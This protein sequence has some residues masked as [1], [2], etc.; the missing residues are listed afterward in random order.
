MK[1]GILS[2]QKI[3]NYGSFLQA[4]SLKKQLEDRGHD[5]Y[6]VD[7]VPG[8][9]VVAA[10]PGLTKRDIL[11]RIDRHIFSRIEHYFFMKKMFANH[12][13]DYTKWLQTD[14]KLP[15]G[16]KYDL[17]IIGSDEVFNATAPSPWG[18]STQLFGNVENAKRVVTYAASCGQTD[19]ES[20]RACGIDQQIGDCLRRLEA[21]SVRDQN[22]YNF[23]E[24]IAGKQA[25]LH[26]DPVFISDY[27]A[28]IPQKTFHKPYMLVYAYANRISSKEEIKAIRTYAKKHGLEIV[29]VGMY[30]R[31]CKHNITATAF[32][33][34]SYV[35]NA[36]CVVT[37]TFHGTVFSIK[38]NKRFAAFI[39]PS[40]SNKLMGLLA[41]FG[42]TERAVDEAAH[43]EDVLHKQVDFA[44]PNCML[45]DEQVRSAAYL[46]RVLAGG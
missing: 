19:Y 6:F 2:M 24:K 40:N 25:Q 7:I 29:S 39:R 41:Q 17:V 16:E 34:L 9:Q 22:T 35:K 15:A 37:D 28:Y 12:V 27:S 38:F 43:L 36:E 14:K 20:A 4:F 33:L 46:D 32:E 21:I 30:Q 42:L 26:V 13:N 11:K 10:L 45:T 44:Q 18:F 31:W 3:H 8:R 1:I 5:V 23:V